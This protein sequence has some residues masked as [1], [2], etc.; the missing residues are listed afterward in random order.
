MTMKSILQNVLETE[1]CSSKSYDE[2]WKINFINFIEYLLRSTS[3]KK[4][5]GYKKNKSENNVMN[6]W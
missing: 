4:G 3:R 5:V 1:S 6:E 2:G